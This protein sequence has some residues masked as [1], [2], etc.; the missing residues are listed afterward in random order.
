VGSQ[1]FRDNLAALRIAQA[2]LSGKWTPPRVR[3]SRIESVRLV[4]DKELEDVWAN[5]KP[6]KEALEAAVERGNALLFEKSA[7][8]AKKEAWK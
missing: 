4:I 3:P 2:Q 5:V 8:P 1:L 6:A 7:R